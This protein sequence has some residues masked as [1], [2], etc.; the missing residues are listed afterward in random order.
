MLAADWLDGVREST[1]KSCSQFLSP[2]NMFRSLIR[3]FRVSCNPDTFT[4]TGEGK[5]ETLRKWLGELTE[6]D[7][8]VMLVAHFPATFSVVQQFLEQAGIDYAVVAE[9]PAADILQRFYAASPKAALLTLSS[10][11]PGVSS[12]RTGWQVPGVTLPRVTMIVLE[13][14]PILSEDERVKDYAAGLRCKVRLGRLLS[15]EDPVLQ[16]TLGGNYARMMEQ[17]GLGRNDLVTSTMTS[18]ALRRS[19][20]RRTAKTNGPFNAFSAEEWLAANWTIGAT[21]S[22]RRKTR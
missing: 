6:E 12:E 5:L 18:R 16:A 17:L 20:S 1:G 9:P 14:S 11:L 2:A 7:E 19:L 15:F 21:K 10:I 3:A 8:I 22:G 4:L 13:A